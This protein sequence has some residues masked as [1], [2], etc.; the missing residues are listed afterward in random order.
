M[1]STPP[2]SLASIP[3]RGPQ[4]QGSDSAGTKPASLWTLGK[5]RCSHLRKESQMPALAPAPLPPE[6]PPLLTGGQY[7]SG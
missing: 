4:G 7:L 3:P 5:H 1:T 2:P 6:A